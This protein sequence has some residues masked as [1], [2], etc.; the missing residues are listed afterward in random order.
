MYKFWDHFLWAQLTLCSIV[1]GFPCLTMAVGFEVKNLTKV[2]K[3]S[4]LVLLWIK[5]GIELCLSKR[6]SLADL[7]IYPLL[8][9]KCCTLRTRMHTPP[10]PVLYNMSTHNPLMHLSSRRGAFSSL[11]VLGWARGGKPICQTFDIWSMDTD[12]ITHLSRTPT[13]SLS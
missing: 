12:Q 8:A 2:E 7:F 9:V 3:G 1:V 11:K 4:R 13:C 5:W 6:S 10:L